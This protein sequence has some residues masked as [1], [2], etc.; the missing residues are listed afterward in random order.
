LI[1]ALAAELR[2]GRAALS[3]VCLRLAEAAELLPVGTCA[4]IADCGG[5]EEAARELRSATGGALPPWPLPRRTLGTLARSLLAGPV[6]A[7]SWGAGSGRPASPARFSFALCAAAEE[8]FAL[9]LGERG[10]R[11]AGLYYTPPEVAEEVVALALKHGSSRSP[12]RVLDPCAGAGAFLCAAAAAVP[13]AAL[14]GA[15]LHEEALRAARAALALAGAR[16]SLLR[17]DSLRQPLPAADLLVGNPPYGH[18]ADAAE[19]SFLLRRMPALR[20]GEID[21]YAA[22]LLRSLELAP[23]GGTV[24]LL[25]PDTWMT[26]ARSGPLRESILDAADLAAVCDLGK[27]FAAA[28]DTRVQSVVL[29]K[30]PFG[31][32]P[33]RAA[34]ILRGRERLADAPRAE[35]LEGAR[36]GWQIYRSAGERRLCASLE[37]SG[38]PLE[39]L[40]AVGYGLRTGDNPRFV[41][42]R[43]PEPGEVALVGGEDV[44]PFALR[45]R[46][47]ALRAPTA[48]LQAL[49]ERQLERPRV[50]IQRI[51][52]NSRAPHA[53]WL[54]A[55][56]V[57]PHLVCLDS[58][59]TLS[60]GD[61]DR[62][63]ALLA[64]L[65][66]VALQRYHRLR[67]TDVN[68]K[69]AALRELPVP[70]AL[71]QAEA[72]G[73]LAALARARAAEAAAAPAH[74]GSAPGLAPALERAI[75]AAVYRLFGLGE[76]EVIEAERGFWGPRFPVEF[77]RLARECQAPRVA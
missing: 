39:E 2:S 26:N 75:D 72:A 45:L 27:P 53:R 38:A 1:G 25:V 17:A 42:R 60:S 13:G 62:L 19:R 55:A 18:V 22:F 67:T 11:S 24:A 41:A 71:L 16:A 77:P 40:C 36:R 54:E 3:L 33:L 20:G 12:A 70:R 50:C 59:S 8:L 9:H 49:A 35:L 28:K 74:T 51:R 34:R 65:G 58:L 32:R 73:A 7:P 21:R 4:R 63:W 37:A 29:V 69:P 68:V 15:D 6:P 30:R 10:R 31:R 56:P 66:S 47:K 44:V 5:A 64:V 76:A 61:A 57:P 52:T 14:W 46:P 43:P 23:A 48:Q